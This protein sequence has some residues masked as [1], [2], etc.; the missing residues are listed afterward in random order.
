ME[1][2]HGRVFLGME[3]QEVFF[4]T[5]FE[6]MGYPV[7]GLEFIGS[8]AGLVGV[9]LAA[10]S[11]ILTWPVGIVN[12]VCFF[13]VFYTARLYSDMLLQFY[14]FSVSI[15]GWVNWNKSGEQKLKHEW[16]GQQWRF[17]LPLITIVA[18]LGIGYLIEHLHILFPSV[19]HEPADLPYLDTLIGVLSIQATFLQARKKIDCWVIW[20]VTDALCTGVY[21]KKGI[22]LV[23]LEFLLFTML[24]IF[25][26]MQWLQKHREELAGK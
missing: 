11:N 3:W 5:W 17:R 4:S 13:F 10:K 21:W 16:I 6:W 20:I 18:T 23:S 12:V 14:Y 25:G 9:Y 15:I 24:A 19:L 8:I 7:S 26:L 1:T 22:H 2:K